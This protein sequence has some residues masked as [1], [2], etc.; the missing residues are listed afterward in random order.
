[1]AVVKAA[2]A[3]GVYAVLGISV[4]LGQSSTHY[5]T[6]PEALRQA[7]PIPPGWREIVSKPLPPEGRPE[8]IVITYGGGGLVNEHTEKFYGYRTA[9][10]AV[11]IRGPCLSA[12]TLITAHI[13]KEQLCFAAGAY[14]AFHAARSVEKG[15]NMPLTTGVM[16]RQQPPEIR[17]WIDRTGGWEN[18]PLDGFWY[19]R[20]RELWAMG[21]PK[22]I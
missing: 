11:E 14:L 15:E 4:A 2:I 19:L 5:K 22:C 6:W 8:R 10:N 20:D 18:L 13:P 12:C 16:Y 17:S 21:Y 3:A 9:G 7:A 1:V